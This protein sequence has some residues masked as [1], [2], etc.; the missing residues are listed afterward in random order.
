MHFADS[1][2]RSAAALLLSAAL[3]AGCG[4]SPARDD[5]EKAAAAVAKPPPATLAPS[6]Q[7]DYAEALLAMQSKDWVHAERGLKTVIAANPDLPGPVV[8]LGIV[9]RQQKRL[10][11]ARSLL[12][13]AV[14]RW[15]DFAPAQHQLGVQL[16]DDGKFDQAD[17]AFQQA[18]SDDPGYAL[19]YYDR[20]V[21]NELYLQRLPVAL[22]N[23]EQFQRLQV[24]PDDQ[25]A[26]W[27]A[28]L[29]RR[30]GATEAAAPAAPTG[31]SP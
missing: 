6:S 22:E 16:R 21:L 30:I 15:P 19:A 5:G 4:G 2:L 24:Q 12:L 8:N 25:V 23:Y 7:S 18:I 26:R 20:A 31:K 3:L 14:K 9:Y 27:I 1:R 28:E 10:E 17:A 11:E 29:Q 13:G